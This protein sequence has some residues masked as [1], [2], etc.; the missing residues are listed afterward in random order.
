MDLGAD[1]W[2][3]FRYVTFPQLSTAIVAGCAARVRTLVRRGDRDDVHVSGQETLPIWIFA[4]LS[5]PNQLPI[6]NVVALFVILL[7]IIP[8]WIAQRLASGAGGGGRF[9]DG[10]SRQAVVRRSIGHETP[11]PPMPQ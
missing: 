2:Q 4:N 1:S 7:S 9:V 11:V 8:V 6:V 3:T 10:R 5:R